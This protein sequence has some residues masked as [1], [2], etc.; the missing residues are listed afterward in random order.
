MDEY[1]IA[2]PIREPEMFVNVTQAQFN[3]LCTDIADNRY[4]GKPKE[5]LAHLLVLGT[6]TGCN[7]H[8]DR[9]L[10]GAVVDI[11]V[12]DRPTNVEYVPLKVVVS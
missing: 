12:I 9:I 7:L 6:E 4:E 5:L 10:A 2:E 11:R 1:N 3:V 8:V